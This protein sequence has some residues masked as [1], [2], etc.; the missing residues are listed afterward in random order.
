MVLQ[1]ERELG[2]AAFDLLKDVDSVTV[3]DA[4]QLKD[5]LEQVEQAI[6]DEKARGARRTID[7]RSEVR[8][9]GRGGTDAGLMHVVKL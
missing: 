9:A 5:L 2:T 3:T 6:D 1:P 7:V 8:T 4:S